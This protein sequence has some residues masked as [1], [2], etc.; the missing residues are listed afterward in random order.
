MLLVT[1]V[2]SNTKDCS[3]MFFLLPTFLAWFDRV[4]VDGVRQAIIFFPDYFT[5]D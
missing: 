5:S 1:R 3:P 4:S 2:T